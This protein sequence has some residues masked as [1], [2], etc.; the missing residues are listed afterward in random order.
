[1]AR[2]SRIPIVRFHKRALA[3]IQQILQ[4]ADSHLKQ[5]SEHAV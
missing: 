4:G 2:L 5:D 3:E 1:V